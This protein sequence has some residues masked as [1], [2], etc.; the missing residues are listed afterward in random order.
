M[1]DS[2]VALA[3]LV[4]LALRLAVPLL[5]TVLLAIYL[6]GLDERWR[7]RAQEAEAPTEKPE[8][9]KIKGCSPE[10]R[11]KCAAFASPLAC[12]QVRRLPNGYLSEACLE[13]RVFRRAYMPVLAHG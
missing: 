3:V 7:A 13:C 9:W 10:A 8:C 4:G 6:R 2:A 12:W 1:N 5:I 11:A